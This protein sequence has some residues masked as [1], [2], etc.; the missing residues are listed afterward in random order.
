MDK[1]TDEA[2]GAFVPGRQIKDNILVAYEI[3]HSFKRK[4]G[5]QGSFTLKLDIS[6]AYNRVEWCFLQKVLTK[7]DFCNEWIKL[8]MT[9]GYSDIFGYL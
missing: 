7:M 9:C 3:L 2:Q 1:Y 6:K 4:H 8:V 5:H